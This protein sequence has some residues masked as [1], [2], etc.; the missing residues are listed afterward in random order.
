[1]SGRTY[2][3]GSLEI[4]APISRRAADNQA[5]TAQAARRGLHP[6]GDAAG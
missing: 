4:T 3:A 6:M 2:Q 1:M 5:S